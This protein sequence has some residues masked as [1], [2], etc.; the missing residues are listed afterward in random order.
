MLPTEGFKF[1]C[2]TVMQNVWC[3]LYFYVLYFIFNM[4]CSAAL[5]FFVG[6]LQRKMLRKRR[7]LRKLQITVIW[8]L[9]QQAEQWQMALGLGL[10]PVPTLKN[11]RMKMMAKGKEE[12]YFFLFLS[13]WGGMFTCTKVP[14]KIWGLLNASYRSCKLYSCTECYWTLHITEQLFKRLCYCHFYITAW[15]CCQFSVP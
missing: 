11:G 6:E 12:E 13:A 9:L 8:R 15:N 2:S 5:V 7:K 1:S 10:T 3:R 14:T 4:Q